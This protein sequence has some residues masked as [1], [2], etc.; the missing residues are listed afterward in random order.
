M[1]A[2]QYTLWGDIPVL[3]RNWVQPDTVYIISEPD[4][5]SQLQGVLPIAYAGTIVNLATDEQQGTG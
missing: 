5:V 3:V 2:R 1:R 4:R